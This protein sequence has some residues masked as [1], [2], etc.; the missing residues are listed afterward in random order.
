MKIALIG[1]GVYSTALTYH[2]EKM[3]DND[4][5]LWTEQKDLIAKFNK[6]HKF[7]FLSKSIKFD[8]NV[9]LSNSL[10]EVLTDASAIF[11]LVGSKYFIDIIQEIKPFYRRNTPIYVG[12]KGM[13]LEQ[14]EF[15]SERTRKQL[16]CNSYSFFAGPTFAKDLL[17]KDPIHFTIAGSNKIGTKLLDRIF[18]SQIDYEY[19]DDL[20]GLELLATLKNIYA[21]GSGILTGQK[22]SE[23]IYYTYLT[24][25][26]K[27]CNQLLKKVYGLP[28]TLFSYGGIGDLFMTCNSKNSRNFMLG[29]M[30]GSHT[31]KEE[32]EKFKQENTIEGY[33][34]LQQI[35][36]FLAKLKIKNSILDKLY[37]IIYQEEK[38]E[39]LYQDTTLE[40]S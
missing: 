3:K 30:I 26:L 8:S 1:T 36:S 32:I 31:S 35:P 10:E 7:D 2:L 12:T 22:V 29:K 14:V 9:I 15:F 23:G 27:E 16:K 25:V 37:Q 4:I 13:N 18:P 28:N 39:I 34:S 5:Y 17:L 20:N 33:E 6:S 38:I 40:E 21:L 11:I 19:T 24:D